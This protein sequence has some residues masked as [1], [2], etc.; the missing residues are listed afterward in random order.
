MPGN[1]DDKEFSAL[2]SSRLFFFFFFVEKKKIK[3]QPQ[4]LSDV[5]SWQLSSFCTFQLPERIDFECS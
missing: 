5:L 1:C 2:L 3:N 4:I